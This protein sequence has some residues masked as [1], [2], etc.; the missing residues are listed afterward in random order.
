MGMPN[1]SASYGAHHDYTWTS[2]MN[3]STH[4]CPVQT[5]RN[6]SQD[7]LTHPRTYSKSPARH[8]T[9]SHSCDASLLELDRSYGDLSSLGQAE[10]LWQSLEVSNGAMRTF[11]IPKREEVGFVFATLSPSAFGPLSSL[12]RSL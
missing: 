12:R 4:S 1:G 8:S 10:G 7:A 6:E 9:R 2:S 5:A 11:R 3:L